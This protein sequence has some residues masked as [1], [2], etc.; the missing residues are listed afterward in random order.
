[1]LLSKM[2]FPRAIRLDDSDVS[3]FELAAEPGEWA[4]PGSFEF[5]DVDVSAL[6]GKRR[7]AFEHGFV[8]VGSFGRTT[9]V[10]IAEIDAAELDT[11]VNE[12]A[13]HFVL[14]YGAPTVEAALPAAR[15]EAAFA[16]SICEHPVHTMLMIQRG[17]T[18]D[19]IRE[20]FKVVRPPSAGGHDDV[21]LWGPAED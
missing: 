18:D 16:Q 14:R 7:E 8:G 6:N 5:Y 13:A 19:G 21:K 20:R 4:V 2:L 1:M 12:L 3:A 10:E 17:L 9:L 11:V 15:E